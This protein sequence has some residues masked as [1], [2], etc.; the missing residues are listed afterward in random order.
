MRLQFFPLRQSSVQPGL[1]THHY[2]DIEVFDNLGTIYFTMLSQYFD[3]FISTQ[4]YVASAED[5]C[6][7][8]VSED[9]PAILSI[10]PTPDISNATLTSG[11]RD[12]DKSLSSLYE[13]Q[14][15]NKLPDS[16]VFTS[17]MD[18]QYLI[19]D[20]PP[21]KYPTESWKLSPDEELRKAYGRIRGS[22]WSNK[23]IDSDESELEPFDPSHYEPMTP[24][25]AAAA[26]A[27]KQNDEDEFEIVLGEFPI[28][29]AVKACGGK[30]KPWKRLP[31]T[32]DD[33]KKQNKWLEKKRKL[34]YRQEEKSK[35]GK[36]ME[37]SKG[38]LKTAESNNQKVV[39]F[40]RPLHTGAYQDEIRVVRLQWKPKP[41]PSSLRLKMEEEKKRA[42][43]AEGRQERD[44][45]GLSMN[46]CD[47]TL[48]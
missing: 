2:S 40:E 8:L 29:R 36:A 5:A 21:R 37:R 28:P 24:E 11:L 27:W 32:D 6:P 19:L 35:M 14:D 41:H 43:H 12:M 46:C 39:V 26:P 7:T 47:L 18:P 22:L 15:P 20:S 1:H 45:S 48:T 30:S 31:V 16:A 17:T 13:P 33:I 23:P 25:E 10:P 34:K 42:H 4:E 44:D 3:P 38:K 9:P